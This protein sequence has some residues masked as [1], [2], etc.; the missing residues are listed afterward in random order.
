[1]GGGSAARGG[2]SAGRLAR[3]LPLALLLGLE[4]PPWDAA[5]A[6]KVV[7][8]GA[9][10]SDCSFSACDSASALHPTQQIARPRAT[11]STV[12]E[13]PSEAGADL[14]SPACPSWPRVGSAGHW[15]QEDHDNAP[16]QSH[17]ASSST[18]PPVGVSQVS[19]SEVDV[20]ISYAYR[21]VSA[22]ADGAER[23]AYRKLEH[24]R[25]ASTNIGDD[26]VLCV[27]REL[28]RCERHAAAAAANIS[29]VGGCE[30][31]S[32]GLRLGL[33][34]DSAAEACLLAGSSHQRKHVLRLL[35]L[36]L[37]CQD[38]GRLP[39]CPSTFR[40]TLVRLVRPYADLRLGADF[41]GPV[42]VRS[43]GAH[44]GGQLY[45]DTPRGG[46]RDWTDPGCSIVWLSSTADWRCASTGGEHYLMAFGHSREHLYAG[47][48]DL[49]F[50]RGAWVPAHRER[51]P[52]TQSK[53]PAQCDHEAG[54]PLCGG[55]GFSAQSETQHT[56]S[57]AGDAATPRLA[58]SLYRE[59][60][61]L[62]R[63]GNTELRAVWD[64]L[65]A[66]QHLRQNG[67]RP[68]LYPLPLLGD[69]WAFVIPA[70]A[71]YT[72]V[73]AI[74]GMCNAVVVC[75]NWLYGVRTVRALPQWPSAAQL[76]VHEHIWG[77]AVRCWSSDGAIPTGTVPAGD[78]QWLR[79]ST[80]AAAS[81]PLI[82]DKVDLLPQAG[83]VDPRTLMSGRDARRISSA[84][85][86]FGEDAQRR[87]P[88]QQGRASERLE[89]VRLVA[90]ELR[91]GKLGLSEP[92]RVLGGGPVFGRWK[93]NGVDMRKIWHGS[94][95]SERARPPPS[96]GGWGRPVLLH[97]C[98][99][100][101]TDLSSIA[102]WT[103]DACLTS[104]HFHLRYE[105]TW[106]SPK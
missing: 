101:G 89:Y 48:A 77:A 6:L 24:A 52:S 19:S 88:F 25:N 85:H 80:V 49:D 79:D 51:H 9:H 61:R 22:D 74:R 38:R 106:V 81:C 4:A 5:E 63:E 82:A 26:S 31:P 7:A 37:C 21:H 8:H 55:D 65:V 28:F 98:T 91:T 67:R 104:C 73:G 53:D 33:A 103:L 83:L 75:L 102:S 30:R 1:M 97:R 18:M 10:A 3:L 2:G 76:S 54:S 12:V 46:Q 72:D 64:R 27:L 17:A 71:G 92:H 96:H 68:P 45:R 66:A 70:G 94:A 59:V 100:R 56:P 105:L 69:N 62:T 35:A 84:R 16:R 95:V 13:R 87:Q 86:I 14:S 90:R 32:A 41:D 36:W 60:A 39:V 40:W 20:P 93:S 99:R 42:L 47:K 11:A 57:P 78:E 34:Y 29:A 50:L 15:E 43:L 58:T 23:A 44:W